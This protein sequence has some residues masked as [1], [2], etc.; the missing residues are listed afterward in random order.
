L[1]SIQT[2]ADNKGTDLNELKMKARTITHSCSKPYFRKALE[3]MIE[4]N[5]ENS[6]YIFITC[7][8]NLVREQLQLMY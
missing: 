5:S 3:R 6:N 2:L 4:K 8:H 7:I 1:A